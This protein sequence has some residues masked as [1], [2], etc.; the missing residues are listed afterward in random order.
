VT[1]HET[2]ERPSVFGEAGVL[3]GGELLPGFALAAR[4]VFA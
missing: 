4:D 3:P 1:V 2:G